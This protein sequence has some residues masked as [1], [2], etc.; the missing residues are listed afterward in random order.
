MGWKGLPYWL[1]GALLD[2]L[3]C[4]IITIPAVFIFYPPL[5]LIIIYVIINPCT[6]LIPFVLDLFFKCA[7]GDF[8]C[9]IPSNI[10]VGL[11]LWFLIA[12]LFSA[13]TWGAFLGWI[14]G[15]IKGRN[16]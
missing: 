5:P 14:Y 8:L 6:L 16:S 9:N 2:L 12:G 13:F 10:H 4:A 7:P 15:K 11:Y 3:I 1:K